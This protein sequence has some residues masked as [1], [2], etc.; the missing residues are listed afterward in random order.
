METEIS[1]PATLV[2]SIFM[3]TVNMAAKTL[4]SVASAE[5]AE[6]WKASD[7]LR[8]MVMLLSWIT[9]WVLRVLM[10]HFPASVGPSNL[11]YVGSFDL[12]PPASSS[13]S[14]DLSAMDQLALSQGFAD[15]FNGP[16]VKALG[17]ALSHVSQSPF[18]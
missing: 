14:Y 1:R 11:A 7:H 6:K 17:R 5:H 8:Y 9:L 10:D 15:G 16:P 2:N 3:S 4:V 12:L 13:S 18:M